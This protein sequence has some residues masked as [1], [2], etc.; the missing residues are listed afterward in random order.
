MAEIYRASESSE[1][2]M[3]VLQVDNLDSVENYFMLGRWI[4]PQKSVGLVEAIKLIASHLKID[5]TVNKMVVDCLRLGCFV[6]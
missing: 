3:V 2:P 5:I 4:K 6:D 1:V